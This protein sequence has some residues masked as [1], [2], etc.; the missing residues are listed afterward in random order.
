MTFGRPATV[1][2]NN[3]NRRNNKDR[4][5]SFSTSSQAK[6][7][8]IS[9]KSSNG[10]SSTTTSAGG[11][12]KK[13]QPQHLFPSTTPPYAAAVAAAA[14]ASANYRGSFT[15]PRGSFTQQQPQ[16]QQ[17]RGSFSQPQQHRGSFQT[18]QQRNSVCSRVSS[19]T[20][21]SSTRSLDPLKIELTDLT[22]IFGRGEEQE[23][24]QATF[25]RVRK[26]DSQRKEIVLVRGKPGTGKTALVLDLRDAISSTPAGYF[27]SS[28]F[29]QYQKTGSHH[30]PYTA[31]VSA[32]NEV[33]SLIASNST[34]REQRRMALLEEIG[35]D[36]LKELER[37]LP[38]LSTLLSVPEQRQQQQQNRPPSNTGSNYNTTSSEDEDFDDDDDDEMAAAAAAA[39]AA[40]NEANNNI[41]PSTSTIGN[42]T[43][44]RKSWL[45]RNGRRRRSH[46]QTTSTPPASQCGSSSKPPSQQQQRTH[47]SEDPWKD[48][49]H[50]L[51]TY[52]KEFI[53]ILCQP[54]KPIVMFIDNLQWAD[55]ASLNFISNLTTKLDTNHFMFIGAYRDDVIQLLPWM[56]SSA[57]PTNKHPPST[58]TSPSGPQ[59]HLI[60]QQSML[61]EIEI[62]DLS[63]QYVDD[64]LVDLTGSSPDGNNNT[65]SG[66]GVANSD[67]IHHA[68][69]SNNNNNLSE[70]SKI[71]YEKTHGN[72]YAIFQFLEMLQRKDLL[73]FCFQSHKWVWD[74]EEI[75]RKTEVTHNVGNAL[76]SNITKLSKEGQTV[77]TLAAVIGMSFNPNIL[78]QIAM[79]ME[80]LLSEFR[81]HVAT[82]MQGI[83]QDAVA[84]GLIHPEQ[85]QEIMATQLETFMGDE[86]SDS[87]SLKK[88]FYEETVLASIQ[89]ADVEGL[90]IKTPSKAEYKFAHPLVHQAFYDRIPQGDERE[91]LHMRIGK[92][93]KA[94]YYSS[95]RSRHHRQ[96]QQQQD[97]LFFAAIKHLNIGSA[98]LENRK[99][100]FDLIELNLRAC[101]KA[102]SKSALFSA[103]DYSK[104]SVELLKVDDDIH[105]WANHYD[106]L[107]R[108]YNDAAE[109]CYACGDFD[110][111]LERCDEIL[112][113]GK[114]VDKLTALY[115]RIEV[116]HAQQK[117]TEAID[118]CLT[119]LRDLGVTIDPDPHRG[120]LFMECWRVKKLVKSCGEE[121]LL[122]IP[123]MVDPVK[124]ESMKFLSLLATLAYSCSDSLLLPM[125]ILRMMKSTIE[126]GFC[127]YTPFSLAGYGMFLSSMGAKSEEAFNYGTMALT[128][129]SRLS[130]DIC[131]PGTHLVV[132][133]F[134]DHLRNP[135]LNGVE[136][137]LRG[138]QAGIGNGELKFAATCMAASTAIGFI[139]AL[140]LKV[141]AEDLKHVCEQLKLLKQD[142]TFTLVAP[143]RQ[144]ALNLIG[145]MAE[146]VE[147]LPYE[148][149]NG[150]KN[151]LNENGISQSELGLPWHNCFMLSY[152]VA[153]VFNDVELAHKKRKEMRERNKGGLKSFHFIVYLE[154]FFSGLVDFARF[155]RLGKRKT[156]RKG[157]ESIHIMDRLV[158]D[159][160]V[161]C[162]GM[163]LLL[164]AEHES[165]NGKRD[166]VKKLYDDAI[167]A[168]AA[169]GFIHF[170]AI[171]SERAAEYFLTIGNRVCAE[172]YM[173]AAI[174]LYNEWGAVAKTQQLVE[175]NKL[176]RKTPGEAPLSITVRGGQQSKT[177]RRYPRIQ[178]RIEEEFLS[179]D[180][181]S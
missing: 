82:A 88:S 155:R 115:V 139:C 134:L 152:I 122:S 103:A 130:N 129:C 19:L 114:L 23:T 96:H 74:L 169:G 98:H 18:Q 58:M 86:E 9:S 32:L 137:L 109:L 53:Q 172:G 65:T 29:R 124:V 161:N 111:S 135:L 10:G 43:K 22:R 100:R 36:R 92:I 156:V 163:L 119:V 159:G 145:D 167:N 44:Q 51:H 72:P 102:K 177:M 144:S 97:E 120:H 106:L 117:P 84:G 132:F 141:Y 101:K 174:R 108:V 31:I 57:P 131:I 20:R 104:K 157:R 11:G 176:Q 181:L 150:E 136:P 149:V 68:T 21:D 56:I 77:M 30:T 133:T 118:L 47:K 62:G 148:Q 113:F 46:Q 81:E 125:V 107:L 60:N 12:D 66:S 15:Q 180:L 90:V 78:E 165:F 3:S 87:G 67:L 99:E 59:Q 158:K 54:S 170:Q 79:H 5:G 24:L 123:S 40:A 42:T 128:L 143:Y 112:H 162:Q 138:Y 35:I 34:D 94:F 6:R 37:L 27:C 63:S 38:K 126:D 69:S 7:S 160:V 16:Q 33:C 95:A 41:T 173:G 49:L 61:T 13:P 151:F 105:D 80:L 140:P 179:S 93:M 28:K 14:A 147:T 110:T 50:H 26:R 164:Q 2:S 116:L 175:E 91:G 39:V 55:T 71:V 75:R 154:T 89:E 45:V 70:L 73:M 166:V 17:Q 64:L 168:F 127:D 171:A 76:V 121:G 1:A 146:Q 153:Y 4:Q 83:I 48:N 142:T 178:G 8:I 85:M 25:V 52:L